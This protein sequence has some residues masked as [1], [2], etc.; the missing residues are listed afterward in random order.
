MANVIIKSDQRRALERRMLREFG[1]NARSAEHREYAEV[2]AARTGEACRE[3]NK[4]DE[5]Y[6]K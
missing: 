5:R 2:I 1:G 3:L 4:M 6:R